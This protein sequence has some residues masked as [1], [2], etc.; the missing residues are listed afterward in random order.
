VCGGFGIN[1]HVGY[2]V[3][4]LV[5][6]VVRLGNFLGGDRNRMIGGEGGNGSYKFVYPERDQEV[7]LHSVWVPWS[8]RERVCLLSFLRAVHQFNL[9]ILMLFQFSRAKI[10]YIFSFP[11]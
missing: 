9:D 6:G 5:G 7:S 3:V 10:I 2:S 11:E 4:I 1:E 8:V